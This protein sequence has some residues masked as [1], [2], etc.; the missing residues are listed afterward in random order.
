MLDTLEVE[1]DIVR[2]TFVSLLESVTK[3]PTIILKTKRVVRTVLHV[4]L[5][6]FW[7][8]NVKAKLLNYY[9]IAETAHIS[10]GEIDR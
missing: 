3:K 1:D 10:E 7:K 4:S 2:P 6:N 5:L 9:L 8:T